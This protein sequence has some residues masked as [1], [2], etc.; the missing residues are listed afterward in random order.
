MDFKMHKDKDKIL[1]VFI[2]NFFLK[3]CCEK[4]IND[5]INLKTELRTILNN[6]G[7]SQMSEESGKSC[8]FNVSLV[9]TNI[10]FLS[11]YL[12]EN[13]EKIYSFYEKNKERHGNI[14]VYNEL[15]SQEVFL[16]GTYKLKLFDFLQRIRNSFAHNNYKLYHNGMIEIYNQKF[17]TKQVSYNET[18]T[19]QELRKIMKECKDFEIQEIRGKSIVLKNYKKHLSEYS[20][21]IMVPFEFINIIT[22]Q[23]AQIIMEYLQELDKCGETY[24]I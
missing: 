14:N 16:D 8:L 24:E 2:Q 13:D 20:F 10:T 11:I 18:T 7:L 12:I 15:K 9:L 6:A 19:I 3:S 21:K 23:I 1:P 17:E 5:S 22:G 4:N